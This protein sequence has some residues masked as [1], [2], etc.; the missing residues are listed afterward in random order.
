MK[1]WIAILAISL[2][3]GIQ[4]KHVFC[5]DKQQTIDSMSA[6]S[7]QTASTELQRFFRFAEHSEAQQLWMWVSEE[8]AEEVNELVDRDAVDAIT[9]G[10]ECP[11]RIDTALQWGVNR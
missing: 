8:L 3:P 1:L 6:Y 2:V 7:A 10:A 11:F 5:L 4:A 9:T